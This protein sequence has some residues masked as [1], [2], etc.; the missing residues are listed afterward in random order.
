MAGPRRLTRFP[1]IQSHGH[2]GK[3]GSWGGMPGVCLA[4]WP[5]GRRGL[6]AGAGEPLP[7]GLA[8]LGSEV[9]RRGRELVPIF[10]LKLLLRAGPARRRLTSSGRGEAGESSQPS[11]P[12]HTASGAGA[13]VVWEGRVCP[14]STGHPFPAPCG[15]QEQ[16]ERRSHHLGV[17]RL[18]GS[19]RLPRLALAWD[20]RKR[21]LWTA[22]GTCQGNQ[23]GRVHHGG[24]V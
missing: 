10:P 24:G 19:A 15:H 1:S 3:K 13:W 5:G 12:P 16:A 8:A 6:G 23:E 17:G 22:A 9:G 18:G 14:T 2:R 21:H 11:P 4:S 20:G 7:A